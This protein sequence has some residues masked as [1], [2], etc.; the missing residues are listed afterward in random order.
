MAAD[1]GVEDWRV[2]G[3]GV[4]TYFRTGS[5]TAGARL[6]FAI[7]ELGGLEAHHPDFDLRDG[8]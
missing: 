3:E 6:V 4:C 8:G 1:S 2:L 7:S 5:F